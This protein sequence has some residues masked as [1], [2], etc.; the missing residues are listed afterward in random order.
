MN[1]L[2]D[3]IDTRIPG[4]SLVAGSIVAM[5]AMAHHPTGAGGS[6]F[7]TFA[8]N[9]ERIAG[10]N[11]GRARYD[12][13]P[14]RGADVDTPRVRCAAGAPPPAGDG[15]AGRLGDRRRDHDHSARISTAS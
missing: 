3:R 14:G 5:T 15:R 9:M 8:R 1:A 4:I 7:A 12:D 11:Q 2:Q 10:V 13:R 6:D